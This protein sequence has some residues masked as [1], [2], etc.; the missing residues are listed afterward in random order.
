[1]GEIR[2][3]LTNF[4]TIGLIAFAFIFIANRALAFAGAGAATTQA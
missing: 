2:V 3:N 4:V 1:M